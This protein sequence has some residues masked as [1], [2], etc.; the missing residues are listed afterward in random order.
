M[1]N[2]FSKAAYQAWRGAHCFFTLDGSLPPKK[3]EFD[4]ETVKQQA[5][6]AMRG[7]WSWWRRL[8]HSIRCKG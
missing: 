8:L 4:F 3:T 6:V 5:L 1:E 2:R 7:E